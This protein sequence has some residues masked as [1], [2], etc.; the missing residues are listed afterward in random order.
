MDERA[1]SQETEPRRVP[2]PAPA[3]DGRSRSASRR[4]VATMLLALLAAVGALVVTL[5]HDSPSAQLTPRATGSSPP[6]A[7]TDAPFPSDTA[8]DVVSYSDHVALVTVI[9]EADAPATATPTTSPGTERMVMRAITFRV[10]D[11]LWS[12]PDA[13]AAP[14][15]FRARW[16]GWLLRDGK[17]TP[18]IVS[19][20]PAV[21]IGAQYVV[22]IA[23]DG[24][25]FAVLQ[26]FAVF[27]F[28]KAAVAL[29][30]QDSPLAR[31]ITRASRNQL[32]GVFASATPD[33]V[34]VPYQ[35]LRPRARLAAVIAARTP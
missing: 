16:W 10:D 14:A 20:A 5:R 23:Y 26:P 33:P 15:T 4:L 21:F 22:P 25:R 2:R 27:R 6:P 1:S 18:F 24:T 8:S 29:E 31:E 34:A 9:A 17:R 11:V 30:E 32:V 35:H 3:G 19:G 7:D 13:P 28:T 12:R